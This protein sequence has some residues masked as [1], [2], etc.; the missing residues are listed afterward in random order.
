MMLA[1]VTQ[2]AAAENE[3]RDFAVWVDGK[4]VGQYQMAIHGQADGALVMKGTAN[5]RVGIFYKYAYN[6]QEVWKDGRLQ[7]FQSMTNDNGK[8]Y[9]VTARAETNGLRVNVNG[10]E[11]MT[12]LDTWVT[13]YWRL[14]GAEARKKV[15]P[16]LDG[17]TGQFYAGRLQYVGVQQL[18]LGGR[19]QNCA[20]YRATGG[21][22]TAD[23]W[24]DAQ[25]RLVRQD[26]VERGHKTVLQLTGVH[27]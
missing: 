16:L 1:E 8:K 15:I 25:E 5:V 22:L 4:Q 21:P 24:Y 20:H 23:L 11:R 18:T 12:R 10:K 2:A 17:D 13:S 3:V 7:T 6:G 19:V 26:T 27:H 9:R 14:P